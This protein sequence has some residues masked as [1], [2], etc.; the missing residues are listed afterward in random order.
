MVS[1]LITVKT[2][3][4]KTFGHSRNRVVRQVSLPDSGRAAARACSPGQL[5]LGPS[6]PQPPT[7]SSWSLGADKPAGHIIYMQKCKTRTHR[8]G[9]KASSARARLWTR[10]WI[11]V[12]LS[13][14]GSVLIAGEAPEK[15]KKR[16]LVSQQI[17]SW[18]C[19]RRASSKRMII[20]SRSLRHTKWNQA[21]LYRHTWGDV[22]CPHTHTHTD[23]EAFSIRCGAHFRPQTAQN[24][25]F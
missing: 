3:T 9:A 17:S 21:R 18:P 24:L 15:K 11:C 25:H 16:Q 23:K 10:G 8:Q 7:L 19:V 4:T 1:I 12:R 22:P 13:S 14:A 6:T 5:W 20:K 2:I